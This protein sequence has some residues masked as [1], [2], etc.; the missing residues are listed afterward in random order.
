MSCKS[1][2]NCSRPCRRSRGVDVKRGKRDG[3]SRLF[4]IK[5]SAV[6][7][8]W[9]WYLSLSGKIKS[10]YLKKIAN[11]FYFLPLAFYFLF[12]LFRYARYFKPSFL[13]LNHLNIPITTRCNLKCRD[14]TSM[15]PYY[16]KFSRH[17]DV[18]VDKLLKN[19]N[20]LLDGLDTIADVVLYG[21]EPFL[22]PESELCRLLDGLKRSEKILSISI[23]IQMLRYTLT[24]LWLPACAILKL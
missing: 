9:P 19:I 16:S 1:E 8:A 6:H 14:C 18:D 11:A 4:C 15:M 2:R 24:N 20:K 17:W 22:F 23:Y 7:D 10:S 3:K 5:H 12:H 21:G 13:C